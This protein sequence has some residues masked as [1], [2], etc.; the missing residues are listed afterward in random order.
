MTTDP[1]RRASTVGSRAIYVCAWNRGEC[2]VSAAGSKSGL[3]SEVLDRDRS[4]S[5][6]FSGADCPAQDVRAMP[7]GSGPREPHVLGKL[8]YLSYRLMATRS[9]TDSAALGSQTERIEVGTETTN[10]A[11]E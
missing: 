10:P 2:D 4:E 7:S 1:A 6:P 9:T 3:S 11:R 8:P 5:V